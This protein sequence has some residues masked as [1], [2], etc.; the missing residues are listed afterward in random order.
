MKKVYVGMS[1]DILHH[2]H[3][4]IIEKA[5]N[6]GEVTVGL[7]TDEAIA[8]FKRLPLLSYEQRKTIIENIRGVKNVIPQKTL[9]YVPNLKKLKPDYV[10][11]GTDWREGMQKKT[12]ER[13]IE[14]LKEWD[15]KIV[16]P[17]YTEGVSSTQLINEML[18]AGTTPQI[19]MKKLRR[20]LELKPLVRILEVHNGLT[21]LIVEKT[22]ITD[23]V[24]IKEF[25]GMWVSSLTESASKG[26]PDIEYADFTSRMHTIEQIFEVTTKPLIFDGDSG[27][28]TE[29]FA[30]TVKTL[31]RLGVSAVIIEDKIGS[32]RNS[33]FG[34]DVNQ[35]QDTIKN[36]SE[37]ISA[38][39]KSQVT[40]DFM[41][42]ARIE[43]L[44]LKKGVEDALDRAKAY[45]KAGA[46]GI[47][48]HSKERDPKEIFDF[49]KEYKKLENKVPLIVIPSTYSH[50]SENELK[51]AGANIVIY[52]NHL[53][54]SAYPAMKRTAECI[55][56]NER[57]HEAEE[58]CLSINDILNLIPK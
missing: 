20:L 33:L 56:K 53:L 16:E 18:D 12:R 17:E 36:F 25:D 52:A 51:E 23:D 24:G 50:I 5:R 7:L 34:T 13:V 39:K 21:G 9:D 29:H 3:I 10:V 30:Y 1:T 44:I 37:K 47:M 35:I 38:G 48:I 49:C 4:K 31:E 42:I 41:I 11:H 32:K 46:D 28:L 15:G 57:A 19:R 2:G 8:T 58:F 54:R 40:D 26:K 6:L 14:T 45:I 22:K 55:L 43:S 27:G